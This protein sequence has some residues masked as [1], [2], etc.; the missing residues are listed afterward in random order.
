MLAWAVL[1]VHTFMSDTGP[2]LSPKPPMPT[3][4]G[5]EQATNHS[6][7]PQYVASSQSHTVPCLVQVE[8]VGL[9]SPR[10]S[11]LRPHP[12]HRV[13]CADGSEMGSVHTSVV[14]TTLPPQCLQELQGCVSLPSA[15]VS[16]SHL[17][18]PATDNCHRDHTSIP[19]FPLSMLSN[20]SRWARVH[21]T[22]TNP[23]V[24]A[25]GSLEPSFCYKFPYGKTIIVESL[26][27]TYYIL[28]TFIYFLIEFS[29]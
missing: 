3:F 15:E 11:E 10:A 26:L 28:G 27:N 1:H 24:S 7:V 8:G 6:Q 14:P 5:S 12:F 22:H 25:L 29:L 21:W 2:R 16:L 4:H 19:P 20:V 17:P 18:T 23:R 9:V 13:M